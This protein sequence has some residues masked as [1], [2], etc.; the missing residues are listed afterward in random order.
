MVCVRVWWYNP[1]SGAR[2]WFE[3]QCWIKRGFYHHPNVR[4]W[5]VPAAPLHHPGAL[6][7]PK[8]EH[9]LLAIAAHWSSPNRMPVSG[10]K[11]CLTLYTLAQY[12]FQ[13]SPSVFVQPRRYR[14]MTAPRKEFTER[15][16]NK[17]GQQRELPCRRLVQQ[18]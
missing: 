7:H 16:T 8:C 1:G 10:L 2:V 14:N 5:H 3:K 4:E 13:S 17:Y 18:R 11:S 15:E 6:Q 12:T 9:V